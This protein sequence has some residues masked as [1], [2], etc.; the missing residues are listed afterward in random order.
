MSGPELRTATRELRTANRE[1]RPAIL[2]ALLLFCAS[3]TPA[4]AQHTIVLVRHAERADAGTQAPAG[5]DPDLAP[6]G[7]TRAASLARVL[8]D[9]K[10][11]QIFTTEYKRTQQTAAPLAQVLELS[12][13]T[14][15]SGS[16]AALIDRIK[17]ANGNVLVVGHSNTLPEVIKRLGVAGLITIPEDQFDDLFVVTTG[18][19]GSA[20]SLVRLH[21]R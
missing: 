8:A 13:T 17:V 9:A 6:E 10:I 18:T 15:P 1:L 21:Y 4:L 5:A 7:R 16:T 20:P 2:V 19:G 14:V 11:T 12:I 3:A